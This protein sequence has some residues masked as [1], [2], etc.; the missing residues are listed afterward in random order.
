MSKVTNRIDSVLKEQGISKQ[1]FYREC[2]I[3]SSAYSQ[4][5]TG[6]TEPRP[7]TLHRVANYLGLTYE[8]LISGI[9]DKEKAPTHEGERSVNDDDIKFAL[10]GGDGEITDAMFEEVKRFA[11]MVKLREEANK[12]KE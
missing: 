5:N 2:E 9:G 12:K 7:A 6:K 10:F 1:E 8:W 4:W 3:T 11:H